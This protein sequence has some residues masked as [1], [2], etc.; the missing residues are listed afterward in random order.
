VPTLAGVVLGLASAV[1]ATGGEPGWRVEGSLGV[2]HS[3]S[4]TLTVEQEGFPT[5]ELDADWEGRSLESPLYYGLR[6][7]RGDARGAWALRFVHLK[8]YLANPTPEVERFSV[9]HGFNLL[10][11]ERSFPLGGFDLWAG[12]GIVIAHPE[13]TIRGRT[14]S[15]SEGGPVGGGYYLTGPTVSVA[16]GRS[17]RVAG[18]FALVPE[19]RVSLSRGRVPIA[20][21]EASVPNVAFHALLGFEIGL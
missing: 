16:L 3:L 10:T 17:L 2:A 12:L 19:V 6:V 15:E 13:S 14:R 11:L 20:G 4:S 5:F 9:S 8:V 1:L 18:R 21:G 7:A